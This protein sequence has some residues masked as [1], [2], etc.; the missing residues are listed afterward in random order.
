MFFF[1]VRFP[2]PPTAIYSHKLRNSAVVQP[3]EFLDFL[4]STNDILHKNIVLFGSEINIFVV[5]CQIK[6][7]NSTII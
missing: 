4:L 2:N 5:R 6:H 1:C 3:V 7:H